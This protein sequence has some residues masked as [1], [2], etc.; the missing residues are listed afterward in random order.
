MKIDITKADRELMMRLLDSHSRELLREIARSD[1][2]AF[3]EELNRELARLELLQT[4]VTQAPEDVEH[5][6]L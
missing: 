4:R 6:V 5:P 3:R 1:S 2:R